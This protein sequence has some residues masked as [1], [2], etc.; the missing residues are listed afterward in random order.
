MLKAGL[1]WSGDMGSSLS[2][3]ESFCSTRAAAILHGTE[4]VS[5][6]THTFYIAVLSVSFFFLGI[7]QWRSS[8]DRVLTLN[9]N[10]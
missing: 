2:C 5:A 7:R 1:R 3:A 6:L 4:P 9:M 8:T 10:I